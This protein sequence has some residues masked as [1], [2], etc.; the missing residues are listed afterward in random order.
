MSGVLLDNPT[1]SSL[2]TGPAVDAPAGEPAVAAKAVPLP[3]ELLDGGELVILAIKPSLWFVLFDSMKWLAACAVVLLGAA[4]AGG[5]LEWVSY[6]AL[7]EGTVLVVACRLGVAVLRWVSR[8]YVLTNRRILRLHGVLK[9]HVLDLPLTD[10]LNTRVTRSWPERW[11]AV[12]TLRFA[13]QQAERHD[14]TWHNI[15]EPDAVHAQVRRAIERALD[16]Q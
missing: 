13:C 4:L 15:A 5:R 14:P 16:R 2:G 11:A 6:A 8:F 3:L 12:G 9:A 7:A 10:V 1:C